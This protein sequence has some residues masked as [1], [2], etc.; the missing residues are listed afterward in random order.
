MAAESRRDDIDVRPDPDSIEAVLFRDPWH[1]QFFQAVRL[2]EGLDSTRGPVGRFHRPSH[3]AARF[4]AHVSLEFPAS[5]IQ[6]LEPAKDGPPRMTVNFMGLIGPLG[7]LPTVIT[8]LVEERVLFKRDRTLRDFLDLFNHR[9]ISLFYQAWEKYRF[10]VAFEREGRARQRRES[11][12]KGTKGKKDRLAQHIL[13]LAGLG[14]TPLQ[15]RSSEVRDESLVYYGGLF[16]QHPPAAVNLQALISDYFGVPVRIQQ[17]VGSWYPLDEETQFCMGDQAGPSQ[18]LGMGAVVGDEVW[19]QQSTVRIQLGPLTLEQYLDFL[20]ED[21][22]AY[23]K[24]CHLTRLFCN[25]IDFEAQLIL[26]RD[27]TPDCELGREDASAPRLGWVTWGKSRPMDR[28]PGDTI[29]KLWP[30]DE[31]KP[32]MGKV[33]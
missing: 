33:V 8:E 1:F 12:P 15:E 32:L 14:M 16:S 11:E 3:E 5:Q 23:P 24:L 6:E 26:K 21:G 29:L 27:E 2:L 19:D 17:F 30:P 28:D 4:C 13:D 18:Q 31:A 9:M 7:V 20:P 10:S 22:R 25:E